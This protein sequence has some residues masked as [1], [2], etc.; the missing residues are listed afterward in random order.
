MDDG[1]MMMEKRV[2]VVDIRIEVGR[3][4]AGR[5]ESR[6]VSPA[7][8]GLVQTSGRRIRTHTQQAGAAGKE[9]RQMVGRLS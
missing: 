3:D 6:P 9:K 8:E 1:M 7:G 4:D 2:G 5:R